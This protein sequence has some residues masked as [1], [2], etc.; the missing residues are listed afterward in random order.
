MILC[1]ID[2]DGSGDYISIPDDPITRVQNGVDF[3]FDAVLKSTDLSHQNTIANKRGPTTARDAALAI[4]TA[5]LIQ[6]AAWN[7]ANGVV[8][9]AMG[10]TSVV[11]G[12]DRHVAGSL[13][14]TSARVF[15]DGVQDG[16]ATKSGTI[17]NTTNTRFLGRDQSNTGR[18]FEGQWAW[19]RCTKGD[20]RFTAGFTPPTGCPASRLTAIGS[21]LIDVIRA[22][23]GGRRKRT[24]RGGHYIPPF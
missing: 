8:F 23:W 4:T 18:D 9:N 24:K 12:N 13:Q 19:Q 22:A 20:A 14:G 2:F 5:G 6:F 7:S 17:A 21:S 1:T 16:T 10:A 3:C 11:Q 15:L